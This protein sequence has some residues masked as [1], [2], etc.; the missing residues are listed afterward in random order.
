MTFRIGSI[1]KRIP[2]VVILLSAIS[3]MAYA[4]NPPSSS[5]PLVVAAGSLR[6]AMDELLAAYRA[7]D[8]QQFSVRYGRAP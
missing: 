1:R 3:N 7:Q 5:S 6:Q 8:G 4:Q 2:Y